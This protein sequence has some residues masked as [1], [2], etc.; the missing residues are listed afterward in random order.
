LAFDENRATRWRTWEPIRAGIYVE[1]DFDR[2]QILSAALMTSPTAIYPL[3][4][5][6]YGRER[7]AW[8]LLTNRPVV[9][10]NVVGDVRMSAMKAIRDAGFNYILAYDSD[11]GNGV[12]GAAMLGHEAEWG[13]EKTASL[14][15]VVLLRI[16]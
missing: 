14:G 15:P 9:T 11:E 4:F 1:V 8:R 10:P 7:D 5:E 2:P 3:P 6:F 16:R 12:L 13:L